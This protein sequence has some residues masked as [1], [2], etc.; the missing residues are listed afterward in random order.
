VDIYWGL[1]NLSAFKDEASCLPVAQADSL[2]YSDILERLERRLVAIIQAKDLI[3]PVQDLAIYVLFANAAI[4]HIY[5]F[6]RD[7]SRGLAFSHLISFRIRNVLELVDVSRLKNQYPEMMLWILMMAGLC[8]AETSER[9]WF[10]TLVADFCLE[11]GVHGGNEIAAMLS[12]FLWTELYR[13]PMTIGFWND[14]AKAQGFEGEYAVRKLSDNVSVA[15]FNA[16][17]HIGE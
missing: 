7:L 3:N 16:P 15:I 5:I 10:A 13:S 1:H 9:S 12:E 11:L 6:L 14:V 2:P 17:P 4:L 8:G